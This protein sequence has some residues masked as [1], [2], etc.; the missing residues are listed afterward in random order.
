MEQSVIGKN[1]NTVER[2]VKNKE[3]KEEVI[4]QQM[5]NSIEK[6]LS[7]KGGSLP[8]EFGADLANKFG[9][10][11]KLEFQNLKRNEQKPIRAKEVSEYS[12]VAI[13]Y[14]ISTYGKEIRDL[15]GRLIGYG[16]RLE[17]KRGH[18]IKIW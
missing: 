17:V 10:S 6:R 14:I 5:I 16:E 15:N 3:K 11:R 4:S 1:R 13:N 2:K 8:S 9:E 18:I 12:K 7:L